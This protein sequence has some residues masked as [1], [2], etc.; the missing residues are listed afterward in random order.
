MG[1]DA[2]VVSEQELNSVAMD[3][4]KSQMKAES[5]SDVF[6]NAD[7]SD[8]QVNELI[9]GKAVLSIVKGKDGIMRSNLS[10]WGVWLFSKTALYTFTFMRSLTQEW[11]QVSGEEY[12]FQEISKVTLEDVNGYKT[13]KLQMINGNVEACIVRDEAALTSINALRQEIRDRRG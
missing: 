4:L 9:K 1:A 11:G 10:W 12:P 7:A 2:A 5:L 13:A 3:M 6:N 8:S